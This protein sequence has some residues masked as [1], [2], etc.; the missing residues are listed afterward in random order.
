[1]LLAFL[2]STKLRAGGSRHAFGPRQ[3]PS[4]PSRPLTLIIALRWEFDGD[5]QPTEGWVLDEGPRQ[6]MG[7]ALSNDWAHGYC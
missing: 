5:G 1:L 4:K 3:L 7:L 2:V 6:A